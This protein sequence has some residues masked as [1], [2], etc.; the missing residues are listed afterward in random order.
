MSITS[1]GIELMDTIFP[2]HK[3]AIRQIF[4]GLDSG[5][6]KMMIEQL[7]KLGYYAQEL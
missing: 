6:K 3:Q 4:G 2:K 1:E 7:K 5:E